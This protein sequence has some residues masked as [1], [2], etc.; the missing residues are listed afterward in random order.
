[1]NKINLTGVPETMLWP[2]YNRAYEQKRKDRLIDDPLSVKVLNSI[3]YDYARNFGRPS[4]GHPLRARVFDDAL[5]V[6]LEEN[7][8]GTI[9][10]LGEG[11]DTQFWRVDNGLL[12][13]FSIDV[14]EAIDVRNHFLPANDRI[15]TIPCSALDFTWME[16]IPQGRSVFFLLSGVIMY[17]TETES[18]RLLQQIANKF[19]GSEIIF[20]MI[21]EW[22][23]AKTMKG[24]YVTKNYKAP[25]MPW[26]LNLAD[27]HKLLSIHP[28][29]ELK[30]KMS[31][32]D[33]YPERMHP[34]SYFR[35][36][37]TIKEKMSP[38]MVHFYINKI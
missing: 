14:P 37:K 36:F 2:L 4:A 30:Q 15:K 18:K 29:L 23:S 13:W 33:P 10:S 22:Y 6:W 28:A 38:W 25:P 11:L 27:C 35:Y 24:M 21:P 17:F 34:F 20:D 26:G 19:S 31:F 5:K 8:E 3:D 1:M 32:I 7:R 9:V 16:H 12:N